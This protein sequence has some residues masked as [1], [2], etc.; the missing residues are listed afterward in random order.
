MNVFRWSLD[1]V[2]KLSERRGS[3]SRPIAWKAIAL[4]AELL[5]HLLYAFL[6]TG[7]T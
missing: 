4:P 5:S 3:N 6:Y 2:L 1:G 7:K